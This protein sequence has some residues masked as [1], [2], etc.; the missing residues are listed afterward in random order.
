MLLAVL[1]G[2]AASPAVAVV[3]ARSTHR[4]VSWR[5]LW[6][7]AAALAVLAAAGLG[8]APLPWPGRAALATAATVVVTAVLVDGWEHRLPNAYTGPLVVLGAPVLVGISWA[9]GWGSPIRA[10]LGLL[11]FGGWMLLLALAGAGAGDAKLAAGVGMWLGWMSWWA[12]GIG[13]V[14]ALLGMAGTDLVNRLARGR[15]RSPLGP[16]IGVGMLVGIAAAA[17]AL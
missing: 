13:V 9:T 16:A 11:I 15:A 10:L 1:A 6:P 2:I 7:A 14:V 12:F 17:L 5:A 4:P 3:A 8:L